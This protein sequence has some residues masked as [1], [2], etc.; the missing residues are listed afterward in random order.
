MKPIS[1]K[2]LDKEYNRVLKK[3]SRD[4][5]DALYIKLLNTPKNHQL[6]LISNLAS[7]LD[8]KITFEYEEITND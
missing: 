5:G 2:N 6:K 8:M 1:Q 4:F 7:F 3:C